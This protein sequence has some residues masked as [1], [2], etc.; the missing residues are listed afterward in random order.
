MNELKNNH[1]V[2]MSGILSGKESKNPLYSF[3][4]EPE[5]A[6]L[7]SADTVIFGSSASLPPPL[8]SE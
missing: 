2:L 7:K 4:D 6:Y 3:F 5:L 1:P 8:L